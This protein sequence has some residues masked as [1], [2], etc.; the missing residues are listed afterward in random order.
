MSSTR[1]FMLFLGLCFVSMKVS[2]Q[3]VSG[4]VKDQDGMPVPYVN[5]VAKQAGKT[6]ILAYTQT[7]EQGFYKIAVGE[8]NTYKVEFSAISYE[9]VSLSVTL[10]KG[11][12]FYKEVVLLNAPIEIAEVEI[13]PNTPIVIKKDTVIF[14]VK[15]FLIGNEQVAEDVLKRLPGIDVDKD[16]VVRANGQEVEKVMVEGDDFLKKGYALLTRGMPSSAIEKVELISKYSENRLLKGIKA[17]D[18][19]VLNLKLSADAKMDWFGNIGVEYGLDK[20]HSLQATAMNMGKKM[21]YYLVAN[22][23]N[24]GYRALANIRSLSMQ[25]NDDFVGDVNAS[26]LL[27][28]DIP[29]LDV[30]E[31]RYNFNNAAITSANVIWHP[32]QDMDINFSATFDQDKNYASGVS[33][34]SFNSNELSFVNRTESSMWKKRR[35]G[36]IDMKI[37]YNISENTMFESVSQ[38]NTSNTKADGFVLFNNAPVNEWLK[39]RQNTFY[40]KATLTHKLSEDRAL[41]VKANYL[42]DY[43]PQRYETDSILFR[44]EDDMKSEMLRQYSSMKVQYADLLLYYTYKW[45]KGNLLE[46]T[47]GGS[48]CKEELFSEWPAYRNDIYATVSDFYLKIGYSKKMGPV[49]M[50][51]TANFHQYLTSL[52]GGTKQHPF[53]VD[54]TLVVEWKVNNKNRLLL[55]GFYKHRNSHIG[56]MYSS[57]VLTGFNS[58]AKGTGEQKLLSDQGVLGSY[59]LGNW[60]DASF[61]SVS[62]FFVRSNRY[63]TTDLLLTPNYSIS[64]NI[65]FKNKDALN[66]LANFDQY[67]SFLSSNIKLTLGLNRMNYQYAINSDRAWIKSVGYTCGVEAKSVFSGCFNYNIGVKAMRT[68]AG[69]TTI[70]YWKSKSFLDLF[71]VFSDRFNVDINSEFLWQEKA[72]TSRDNIFFLDAKMRYILKKNKFALSFDAKNILNVNEFI[73]FSVDDTYQAYNSNRLCPRMFL[74][75]F[76]YKF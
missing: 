10:N 29:A 31:N 55:S 38:Y 16:G 30:D 19:V 60:A 32:L 61:F 18:K 40:E 1:L 35:N 58:L 56:E 69:R 41:Q 34:Q 24:M 57:Y 72:Y 8:G 5:V 36:I 50:G 51:G 4:M 54:P 42:N 68:S 37:A 11:D 48:Y 28:L 20:K 53:V 6:T 71:F 33:T 7:N 65:S 23:N 17:S 74:L 15:A 2:S 49:T 63:Y 27:D 64:Q 44:T 13:R 75:G 12:S 9:S 14:N 70:S 59:Q 66:L 3:E 26:K 67:L 21:K 22:A 45:K 73:D 47:T 62:V 76:E 52:S 46:L 43:I 25:E 39:T